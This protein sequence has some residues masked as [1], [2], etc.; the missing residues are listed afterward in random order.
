MV[1]ERG[2]GLYTEIHLEIPSLL[3]DAVCN[4]IIE[5][6]GSGLVLEEEEGSDHT[7]IKFYLPGGDQTAFR[8]KLN[9]YLS[10]LVDMKA[11]LSLIPEIREKAI[12]AIEWEE[13]YR[14]SVQPLVVAGDIAIRPP[15]KDRPA[16]ARY[17]LIIEPR[18]AFGTGSHESTRGCLVAIREKLRAGMRFLDVGCGSGILSILADRMGASYIKAVDTD[19]L[20]VENCGENFLINSVN[21]PHDI[22]HG[23]IAACRGDDPY[24]FV[25]VNIIKSTILDMLAELESLT[26]PGGYLVLAGLLDNDEPEMVDQLDASG[27][28]EFEVAADGEWRTFTVRKT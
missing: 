3:T 20:A 21:A 1:A 5:T 14:S 7:G 12:K 19:V 18:M 13:A 10:S 27:L 2:S 4:Y 11:G 15:W 26:A 8:D 24:D 17:D 22:V 28:K 23:S 9:A 25:C 16:G 6:T